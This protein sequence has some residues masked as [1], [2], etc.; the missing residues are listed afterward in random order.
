M[1]AQVTL[2]TVVRTWERRR[3][4][5]VFVE[6]LPRAMIPGTAIGTG[7]AL[8]SRLR[9]G[10][11]DVVAVTV[12]LAGAALGVLALAAWVW[13]RPR[14]LVDS[15]RWFDVRFGLKERVSTALELIDGKIHADSGLAAHQIDDA[16]AIAGGVRANVMLPFTSD[17][18]AWIAVVATL[19]MLA[20]LIMLIPPVAAGDAA[21]DRERAAI[22]AAADQVAEILEDVAADPNLSDEER[23]PLLEALQAQLETMRDPNITLDEALATLSEVEGALSEQAEM[24]QSEIEQ[25]QAAEDAAANALGQGREASAGQSLQ[26]QIDSFEQSLSEMTQE[27]LAQ[28]AEALENAANALEQT[29]PE[30][31]QALRE[32]AEALRQGDREA[33]AEALR[34]AAEQAEQSAAERAQQAQQRQSME[35]R[36]QQAQ[37]AQ[38]EAAESSSEPTA[39]GRPEEGSE[40]LGEAQDGAQ[41]EGMFGQQ[42][43][44]GET[45]GEGGSS[46]LAPPEDAAQGENNEAGEAGRGSQGMG[47]GTADLSD[48]ASAQGQ[49]NSQPDNPQENNPDGTGVR[50]YQPVYSPRFSVE[51]EDGEDVRLQADPGDTPLN[52]G[53][54]DDN[55]LGQSVV[56]YDTVFSDYANAASR[57]LESGYIPLGMRD[58]IRSYF[59]SLDPGAQP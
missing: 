57:A 52:Q 43:S 30:A 39:S 34:R 42:A 22:A 24:A 10:V 15:A 45:E 38:E 55:P 41:G 3:Q 47:D 50:A 7:L 56:P 36:A 54:F 12:A 29:D 25:Q 27:Q 35:E 16:Q 14:T 31:A 32:A 17:R 26:E 11:E 23:G 44:E 40:G 19:A 46:Q 20:I 1:S 6:N 9:P 37:A 58:V 13:L 4:L 28:A 49:R 51:A 48:D 21:A 18:R 5:S 8:I 2:Q 53:E 33:A 59:S